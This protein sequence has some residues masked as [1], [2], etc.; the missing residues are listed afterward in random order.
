MIEWG[1]AIAIGQTGD[2]SSVCK[3]FG[4]AKFFPQRM[5]RLDKGVL[6]GLCQFTAIPSLRKRSKGQLLL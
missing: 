6:L 5:G 3:E 4:I 2:Q 1:D